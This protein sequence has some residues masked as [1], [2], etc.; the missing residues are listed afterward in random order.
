[1]ATAK[2]KGAPLL[3]GFFERD[4]R[5]GKGEELFKRLTGLRKLK[6]RTVPSRDGTPNLVRDYQGKTNLYGSL[7]F[8]K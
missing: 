6:K 5:K 8:G 7:F 1:M 3:Y 2:T 4:K